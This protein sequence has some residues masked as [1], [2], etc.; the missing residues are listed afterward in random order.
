MSTG[1]RGRGEGDTGRPRVP[2]RRPASPPAKPAW[3]PF[4]HR[5]GGG[6]RAHRDR[7]QVPLRSDELVT[8]SVLRKLK[9][10]TCRGIIVNT[11][12][13]FSIRHL[14]SVAK[15]EIGQVLFL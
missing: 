5:R 2:S 9:R 3:A 4:P 12:Y 15:Q 1:F 13:V 14:S 7:L 6:E 11:A 8:V 10:P